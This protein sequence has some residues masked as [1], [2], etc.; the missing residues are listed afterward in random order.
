MSYFNIFL[1]MLLQLQQHFLFFR[2]GVR[3]LR[4]EISLRDVIFAGE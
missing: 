3:G 2:V 4:S 1:K